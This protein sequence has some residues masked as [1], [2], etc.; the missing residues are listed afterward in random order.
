M[1]KEDKGIE[2]DDSILIPPTKEELK[3]PEEETEKK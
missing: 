1:A 2:I 3:K